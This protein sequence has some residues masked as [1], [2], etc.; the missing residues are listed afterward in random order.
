[1]SSEIAIKVE[2]LSKCYEIYEQPRDR[3]KQFVL[4]RMQ[5]LIGRSPSQFYREFWALKD[6]SFDVKKGESVGIVGRN[7]SG[8]S[9]LLQ[10]ITG[11]LEPTS[12]S[13]T[14]NG[15]IAALLE[16]GSGFNP[17]FTGRENVY[18]NGALLGFSTAQVDEKFDAIA[19]FA[20]IGEHLDQPVKTYSSGML[21]RLAFAVQVQVE[22]EI[23]IVDE[24]LAVGDALFQKRCFQRIEKLVSDGTTLL[25]VSHDQESV[26]TLTNRALLLNKGTP[27]QWGLS[28]EVVLSYRKLLHDEETAY[29]S[30]LTKDMVERA[31]L[32]PLLQKLPAAKLDMT[33][34]A[35]SASVPVDTTLGLM[36]SDQL[37]FGDEK[38]KVIKVETLDSEGQTCSMFYVGERLR[39]RVTCES[40]A[41]IDKL[42]VAV[43]LR[44]KEG[45]KIYSWGT[46]NQDMSKL[47]LKEELFWNR[48]FFYGETF[49]V[50]FDCECSLG[51]NLYEV[52]AAV[53]QEL[54]P[55]YINQRILHW[56]DEAAFFQTCVNREKNFF[57]GLVDL[58][59]KANW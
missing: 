35:G 44:N 48:H 24:A 5:Q 51:T 30:N 9:T 41:I 38:V 28:S 1:M 22:P 16:L 19:A 26:R 33:I 14:T 42:N 8:K 23:L 37:S 12:G 43:R 6:V 56:V 47:T 50:L 18:L 17:D 34:G 3:L 32:A 15:R 25:F 27:I 58:G 54:T 2:N 45:V 21:V 57:G 55:D 11:T 7:G 39:I 13:V 59:M 20:D 52:Q 4:P 53:S 49:S 29:F 40:F 31:R 36:R 46:L 10:I